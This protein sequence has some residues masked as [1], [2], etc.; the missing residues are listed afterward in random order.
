M[1][2]FHVCCRREVC[3]MGT[4]AGCRWY[5]SHINIFD[6]DIFIG[7]LTTKLNIPIMQNRMRRQVPTSHRKMFYGGKGQTAALPFMRP[8]E[9]FY[10]HAKDQC[11]RLWKKSVFQEDTKK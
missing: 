8:G 11:V 7:F 4:A 10:R 3:A 5:G 1:F 9:P 2:F 6:I